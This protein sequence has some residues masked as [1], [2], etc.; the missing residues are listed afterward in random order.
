MGCGTSVWENVDEEK[1]S[2]DYFYKSERP[3]SQGV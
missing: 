1:Q 2:F 3:A